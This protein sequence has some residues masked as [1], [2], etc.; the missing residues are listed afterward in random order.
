[1]EIKEKTY[2]EIYQN[3]KLIIKGITNNLEILGDFILKRYE[4]GYYIYG[5]NGP[6]NLNPTIPMCF[7]EYIIEDQDAKETLAQNVQQIT[8]FMRDIEDSSG[9]LFGAKKAIED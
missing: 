1:M 5:Y 8:D 3:N 4:K 7:I 9:V 2:V 6:K